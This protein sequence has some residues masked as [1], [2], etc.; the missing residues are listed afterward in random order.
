[1]SLKYSERVMPRTTKKKSKHWIKRNSS[2]PQLTGINRGFTS[3][4]RHVGSVCYKS[5]S[6][7]DWFRN[8]VDFASKLREVSQHFRHLVT[9][10]SATDVND[11]IGVGILGKWLWNYSLSATKSTW[12]S[13][14]TTLDTPTEV[15][16]YWL[17]DKA[18]IFRK[19]LREQGIQYALTC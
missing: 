12:N 19:D 5:R 11:D 4:D 1:M 8:S 14:S 9:T 13:G 18:P 6:L 2:L 16:V 10:F 3:S 7:H 15:V 17:N